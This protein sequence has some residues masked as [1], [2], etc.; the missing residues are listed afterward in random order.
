MTR[1]N[2][3]GTGSLFLLL[4]WVLPSPIGVACAVISFL[5]AFL[6]G[7]QGSK[8]WFVVPSAIIALTLGLLYIGFHAA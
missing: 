1:S 4:G 8:W 6:A 3:M 5:L 7:Q 2:K